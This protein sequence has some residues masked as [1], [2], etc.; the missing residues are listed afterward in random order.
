MGEKTL[1][2]LW[3][4]LATVGRKN[5]P[6]TRLKEGPQS[7]IIGKKRPKNQNKE[8]TNSTKHKLWERADKVNEL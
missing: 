6:I 1:K 4:N 5:A 8:R 7:G 2:I 3:R